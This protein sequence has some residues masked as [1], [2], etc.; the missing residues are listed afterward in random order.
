MGLGTLG[1]RARGLSLLCEKKNG[2]HSRDAQFCS[3]GLKIGQTRHDERGLRVHIASSTDWGVI[4]Q[5][6]P[7]ASSTKSNSDLCLNA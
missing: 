4:G 1:S 6:R 2:R 7:L 5:N 3:R